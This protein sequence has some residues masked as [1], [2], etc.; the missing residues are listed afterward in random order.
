MA[1]KGLGL[2]VLNPRREMRPGDS[3]RQAILVA[4]K[5]AD[6]VVILASAPE[7][8]EAS[9]TSYDAG[10]AEASDKPVLVLLP[11]KYS[12]AD[13]PDDFASNEIVMCDPEALERAAHDIASR[14]AVV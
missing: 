13:L 2:K 5:Q 3:W 8:L 9:W 1:L 12:R 14:L 4:L 6:V 11:N 10:F 7:N